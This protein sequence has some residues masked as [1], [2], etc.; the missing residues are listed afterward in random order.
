MESKTYEEVRKMLDKRKLLNKKMYRTAISSSVC[1]ELNNMLARSQATAAA[2]HNY[3][4]EEGWKF[5]K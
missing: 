4:K 1:I 5:E 2:A 3:G